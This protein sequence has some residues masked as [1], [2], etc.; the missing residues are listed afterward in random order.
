MR[1]KLIVCSKGIK[2]IQTIK[3]PLCF[4]VLPLNNTDSFFI[5]RYYHLCPSDLTW[6]PLD[7][8][9]HFSLF[10]IIKRIT[11]FSQFQLCI[12]PYAGYIFS[13]SA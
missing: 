9:S 6:R 11:Y 8:A 7:L 1:F 4:D 13:F 12:E 10:G 3:S 2:T 5:A